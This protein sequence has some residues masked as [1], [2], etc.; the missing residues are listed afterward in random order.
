MRTPSSV[1]ATR[2]SSDLPAG[3]D[4]SDTFGMRWKAT[5]A[6]S[7]AYDV[8]RDSFSPIHAAC[9]RVLGDGA[10]VLLERQ[11]GDVIPARLHR[12]MLGAPRFELTV[13]DRGDDERRP[14][15]RLRLLDARALRR[16]EDLVL[17]ERLEGCRRVLHVRHV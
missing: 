1:A 17:A 13:G 6:W 16:H 12:R 14:H 2:S 15:A 8:P 7:W 10:R 9:S 11:T 3:E 5:E 4:A